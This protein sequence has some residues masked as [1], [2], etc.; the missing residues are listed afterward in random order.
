MVD[1]CPICPIVLSYH[2]WL[3]VEASISTVKKLSLWKCALSDEI[4][5]AQLELYKKMWNNANRQEPFLFLSTPQP[6][7]CSHDLKAKHS[8]QRLCCTCAR[9]L[10]A[11][12][13]YRRQEIPAWKHPL[14]TCQQHPLQTRTPDFHHSG[15]RWQVDP[16]IQS[17]R[18][19]FAKMFHQRYTSCN[20]L[21][22]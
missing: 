21:Q 22:A 17:L 1:Y 8:N 10:S 15:R 14:L 16:L 20:T 4:I 18:S 13:I 12:F 9:L 2:Q 3:A 11:A 6:P 19:T 7:P 5:H